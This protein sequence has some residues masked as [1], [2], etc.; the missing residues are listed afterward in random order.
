MIQ[1]FDL[2]HANEHDL[3]MSIIRTKSNFS[4]YVYPISI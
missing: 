2:T 3:D 4:Y 1:K